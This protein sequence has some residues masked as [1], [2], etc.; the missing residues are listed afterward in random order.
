MTEDE[1]QRLNPPKLDLMRCRC[2]SGDGAMRPSSSNYYGWTFLWEGGG[3]GGLMRVSG[4]V[5]RGVVGRNGMEGKSKEQQNFF[6]VS[7][8]SFPWRNISK[9]DWM[10]A[11]NIDQTS[12]SRSMR[13]CSETIEAGDKKS[14]LDRIVQGHVCAQ[15]SREWDFKMQPLRTFR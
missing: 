1:L 7:R 14:A 8:V 4:F 11:W 15:E 9:C 10:R 3:G 5:A 13:S 12:I 6:A 2:R